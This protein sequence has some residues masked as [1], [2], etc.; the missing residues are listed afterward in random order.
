MS[1]EDTR[2]LW[3]LCALALVV[4]A[5]CHGVRHQAR[6]GGGGLT[7]GTEQAG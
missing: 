7:P 3:F 4:I 2:D 5:L 1:S 6:P